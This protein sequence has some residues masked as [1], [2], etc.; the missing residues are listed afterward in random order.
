VSASVLL[1]ATPLAS[2]HALRGIGAAVS[3]LL[4]GLSAIGAADRVTLLARE[5]QQIPPGFV[6]QRVRWR[7]WRSYRVPDPWPRLRG[8]RIV[9]RRAQPLFHATQSTLV[10]A[11]GGVVVTVYDLI[12]ALYWREYLGGPARA[13]MRAAY[14]RYLNRVAAADRV[15][16]ISHDT[17]ADVERLLDVP[18]ERIRV[19]PLAA[20]PEAAPRGPTPHGP[21]LLYVGALEHHKNADMALRALAAGPPELRLVAAGAWSDRRLRHLKRT[22]R[23]LG[24][25]QRVSW[26]GHVDAGRLA[27]LRRDA[28]AVLVPSLKE[29]F[30][31]PVLEGMRA[32]TAVVASDI[33]VLR[34]VGGEAALYAP[35][36]DADAWGAHLARLLEDEPWRAGLGRTGAHRA[37][38]FSWEQTARLTVAAYDELTPTGPDDG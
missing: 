37:G 16:A 21:Y 31:L 27:A 1:D 38:T 9:R 18:Q 15:I 20:P 34:E 32:G 4:S 8:E 14:T 26:L 35:P 24:V 33:E 11:G 3:G 12:P 36:L 6:A 29:G 17:A 25:A 5:D 22:A 13:L 19:V 28:L 7:Q 10:P 23:R 2:A 30:G